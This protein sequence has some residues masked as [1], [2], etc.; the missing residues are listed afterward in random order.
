M[1][2]MPGETWDVFVSYASE[3]RLTA[4]VPLRQ[5]LES[6]GLRVWQDTGEIAAGDGLREKIND[7][8]SRSRVAVVVLSRASLAKR[9]PRDEWSALLALET[10]DRRRLVP[11]LFD[12]SPREVANEF[13]L[14]A[15]RLSLDLAA[16]ADRVAEGVARLIVSQRDRA[17]PSVLVDFSHGQEKWSQLSRLPERIAGAEKL[18]T[19]WLE[20]EDDLAHAAVLLV[21][22]PF[23]TR[24]TRPEIEALARW[25]DKGG[26]LALFGCYDE[27]HHAGNPSKLAW[28]FDFEFGMDVVL[29]PGSGETEARTHVFSSDPR[30]AVAARPN[31]DHPLVKDVAALALISSASVWPLTTSPPELLIESDP[32]AV[33]MR[34]LGHILPD[35][36]RPAIERWEPSRRGPVPLVAARSYGAGRIVVVGTWKL[37][38]I[39]SA[40]NTRFLENAIAWL[41]RPM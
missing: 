24:F 17:R 13:P 1:S 18:T 21:P 29:P 36:S 34:P 27:R 6:R 31:G 37:C 14:I 40:Q 5:A 8:L 16:G 4:A 41:R 20:R 39:E 10:G 3:D 23:H 25:V 28:C 30:L 2:T 11:V 15:D 32:D 7:G 19:S 9:W 33:V 26:G 22:P 35:G 38:T 12:V